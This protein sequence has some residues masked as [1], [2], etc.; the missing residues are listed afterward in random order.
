MANLKFLANSLGP[1]TARLSN[2]M[3]LIDMFYN[4]LCID[5]WQVNL[6]CMVCSFI[7]Q[8]ILQIKAM[9]ADSITGCNVLNCCFRY[10]VKIYDIM[11]LAFRHHDFD[12]FIIQ[13]DNNTAIAD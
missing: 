6:R 9:H 5:V 4:I 11:T 10:H 2:T 8:T 3:P 1:T 7:R 13:S 12:K